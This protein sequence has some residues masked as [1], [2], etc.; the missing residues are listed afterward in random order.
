ME[1][2]TYTHDVQNL[3]KNTA[4]LLIPAF[5][6]DHRMW[7]AVAKRCKGV[8]LITVDGPGFGSSP[9]SHDFPSI[10]LFADY[11][12]QAVETLGVERLVVCG[13]GYGGY[14][15][16]AM[17]ERYP[18][19]VAGLCLVSTDADYDDFRMRAKRT[20]MAINALVG[21]A[22]DQLKADVVHQLSKETL[23]HSTDIVS[24]LSSW[25]DDAKDEG[26]AWAQRSMSSRPGRLDALEK[27]QIP[28]V[29]LRGESDT[30]TSVDQAEAMAQRLSV[31]VRHVPRSGYLVPVEAPGS[32]A[33][34]LIGL[35][36]S[37]R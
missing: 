7:E 11:L 32:V 10:D 29:I 37:C 4:V 16:L 20:E 14:A 21:R 6:Y 9:V 19:V 23:A 36:A 26:I 33:R 31:Q 24:L 13:C 12:L 35:Y 8:P 18:R 3:G 2:A 1:L 28:G 27:C 30:L 34:A 5:P 22:K 25:I 15:A 17:A